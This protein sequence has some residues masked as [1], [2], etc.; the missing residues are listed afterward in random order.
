MRAPLY[1]EVDRVAVEDGAQA[2]RDVQHQRDVELHPGQRVRVLQG[3][4]HVPGAGEDRP[5]LDPVVAQGA[6]RAQP[7]LA[8]PGEGAREG[9]GVLLVHGRQQQGV[10]VAQSGQQGGMRAELDERVVSRGQQLPDHRPEQ[11][12]LAQV[13]APVGGVGRRAGAAGD[14]R[15]ER[16]RGRDRRQGGQRVAQF[17]QERVDVVAVAGDVGADQAAE[18]VLPAELLDERVDRVVVAGHHGRAGR[19]GG[20]QADAAAAPV[21]LLGDHG[22]GLLPAEAEQRHRARPAEP[23]VEAAADADDP[24]RLP[25][26]HRARHVRGGDLAQAVPDHGGGHDAVGLPQAGQPD[27]Q[28]EEGGLDDV[29][30]VGVG[31]AREYVGDGSVQIRFERD[32]ALPD[33]RGEGRFLLQQGASHAAPLGTLAGEDEND[34]VHAEKH[35]QARRRRLPPQGADGT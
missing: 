13:A 21:V 16:D 5:A 7:H 2:A 1:H 9:V 35:R 10:D 27:L 33:R 28:G 4:R 14:G 12:G 29:D 6:V 32:L 34:T 30:P 8:Q 3:G 31:P 25:E 20:G 22:G 26:G 17:G 24:G 19:V 11:D 23:A 15:P 18:D